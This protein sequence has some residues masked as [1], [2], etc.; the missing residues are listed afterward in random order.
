MIYVDKIKKIVR[1]IIMPRKG[2]PKIQ[3][4]VFIVEDDVAIDKAYEAK[5]AHE[6]IK[7]KIAE[8]GEEAIQILKKG[9]MPSLILLDLMLPKK[10]GFE[11]LEEIKKD[12]C[13]KDIPVLL[14]TNLAQEIDASRGLALGAEEYLVKAD[15]KIDDL[16]KKV[17]HYLKKSK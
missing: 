3:E 6:G 4:E 15:T 1:N 10:S 7:I 11:V 12:D 14:L 17:R 13:L 2:C 8:D 9:Y 5:F 16:V